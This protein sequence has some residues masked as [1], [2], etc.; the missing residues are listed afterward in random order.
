MKGTFLIIRNDNICQECQIACFWWKM[1]ETC[2]REDDSQHTLKF[3][4]ACL[5]SLPAPGLSLAQTH[6]PQKW[7]DPVYR[8]IWSCWSVALKQQESSLDMPD[9]AISHLQPR[10]HHSSEIAKASSVFRTPNQQQYILLGSPCGFF[11]F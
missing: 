6:L 7:G 8:R 11:W 1:S 9:L 10:S 2:C 5:L 4:L 3:F